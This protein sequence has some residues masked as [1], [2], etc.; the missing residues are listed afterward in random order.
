MRIICVLI[1]I[2]VALSVS[3][4]TAAESADIDEAIRILRESGSEPDEE[5]IEKLRE[6]GLS[7]K[8]IEDLLAVSSLS[9]DDPAK[10][11][12]IYIIIAFLIVAAVSV[13]VCF[14][15]KYRRS[16]KR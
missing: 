10:N 15:A 6:L 9:P 12:V 4:C 11:V 7:D 3:V 14:A 1:C 16:L 2:A 8:D 5:D 13:A